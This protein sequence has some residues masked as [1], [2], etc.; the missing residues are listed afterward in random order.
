MSMGKPV[1]SVKVEA[2]QLAAARK[3]RWPSKHEVKI[4]GNCFTGKV[5][6]SKKK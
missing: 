3:K 6:H 4:S 5:N 2:R 1:D